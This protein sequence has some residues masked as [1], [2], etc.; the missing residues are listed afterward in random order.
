MIESK[1]DSTTLFVSRTWKLP[2]S[3]VSFVTRSVAGAASRKN[4]VTVVVPAAAGAV[5]PDGAFDLFGAGVGPDGSWPSPTD[6]VWPA[7]LPADTT[8]IA[9]E[10]DQRTW[11]LLQAKA[12]HALI[13]TI[14]SS[15]GE[16]GPSSPLRFTGPPE[17]DGSEVIGLHVPI[18]PLAATHRHNGLGFTGYLLVLSDRAGVPDVVPPTAMAAWL[19]ARFPH[20][21]VVVIE[22]A[23]AAV[24]RGRVLRGVVSVFTRT[25]LWR[26]LAHARVTIDLAPGP[27]VARECVESLR[28]ATPIV[29]PHHSV[30]RA[31]AEAGG[32]L[33]F[34]DHSEL[35]ACIS[36][37]ADDGVRAVMSVRGQRYAEARYGDQQGFVDSV[38]RHLEGAVP[39]HR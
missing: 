8:I 32:G 4:Q 15:I 36:H 24:W 13:R 28:F 6:T 17:A 23:T 39:S 26:L 11:A 34:R 31:H 1:T 2:E 14:S 19:T 7:G 16:A 3:E 10:L 18:N 33:T 20:L 12:R 35:L 37:L 29:V 27:I 38:A 22:D 30:A 5:E 25:D 21:E 9:D